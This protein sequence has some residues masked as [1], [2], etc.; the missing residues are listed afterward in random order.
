MPDQ[1][2]LGRMGDKGEGIT[3][4]K[5]PGIKSHRDVKY[6]VEKIFNNIVKTIYGIG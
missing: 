1:M 6:S 5:L 3:M 2:R 4:Y